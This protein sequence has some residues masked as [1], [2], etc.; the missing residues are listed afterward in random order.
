MSQIFE[1]FKKKHAKSQV[2]ADRARQIIPGGIVRDPLRFAP[3]PLY[4][5]KGEGARKWDVD[6]NEYVDYWMGHGTYLTGYLPSD[7]VRVLNEQLG[8]GV[9]LGGCSEAEIRWAE[10]IKKM[11][12]SAEL[13]RFT[14]SGSESVHLVLRLAR[15]FT[16]RS[17]ILKFASHFHGWLDGTGIGYNV[18]Y[19]VPDSAGIP[20]ELL[21][22]VIVCAPNDESALESLLKAKDIAAVILEPSGGMQGTT[23]L[24]PGFQKTLR[25]LT[26]KYGTLLIFDEMVTGFRFAPGGAQQYFG[27]KPDL[28]TFGKILSGGMP[29]S[30]VVGRKDIMELMA[31]RG[32]PHWD[33]VERVSHGGTYT[34]NQLSALAGR[35]MLEAIEDG[36]AQ[37]KAA[38]SA[39]LLITKI[40]DVA[41]VTGAP[42]SIYGESSIL[43]LSFDGPPL[44]NGLLKQPRQ[45]PLLAKLRAALVNHGVDMI[46]ITFNV[47]SAHTAADIDFTANVFKKALEEMAQEGSF[48]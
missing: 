36:E 48:K 28:T 15:A 37:K 4:I 6:G 40:K 10:Q 30:A 41:Q 2:L 33:R 12:P 39:A 38:D 9:Q 22:Q 20:P 25:E 8:R 11:V 3:F 13:V 45:L 27:I 1:T 5:A 17:K 35:L 47:S 29:G 24:K 43:H 42:L 26:E 19:D 31:F 34:G 21:A 23:L 46:P 16:K 32:D 18:P 44:A 14:M 7:R